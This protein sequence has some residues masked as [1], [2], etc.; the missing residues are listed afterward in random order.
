MSL[1]SSQHP[2]DA[3]LAAYALGRLDPTAGSWIE[4][5][6]AECPACRSVAE[7]TPPDALL[8]L[9]RKSVVTLPPQ[10]SAT[11]SE[12]PPSVDSAIVPAALH[13][14]PKYRIVRP[15]GQGGMGTVFL[16]EHRAME[17]LVAVKVV[18]RSLVDRP[19]AV[20]RF[21]REIKAAAKLD[22]PNIVRAYDAEPAGDLQLL[23]MEYVEGQSLADV[24]HESGPLPV[25]VACE[26]VR[27]AALG[28]QH[29]HEKGMVHRD[30]KPHNL[31]LA[32]TGVVKIL[33]FGL[34]KLASERRTDGLTRENAMMG[35]PEYLAPE[36]ARDT[37]AADVRA[38]IYALGCTLF[39]LLTGR[40]P[41]R[42]EGNDYLSVVLAHLEQPPPRVTDVR[43]DVPPTLANLIDRMLA[44]DPAE[45]PQTPG[46]VAAALEPFVAMESSRSRL[47]DRPL[48]RKRRVPAAL[49]IAAGG[50]VVIGVVVALT[51]FRPAAPTEPTTAADDDPADDQFEPPRAPPASAGPDLFQ[52]GSVWKG[53]LHHG[54]G[55]HPATLTV[56]DRDGETFRAR[57]DLKGPEIVRVIKKGTI[58]NGAIRWAI[59]DVDVTAG[60]SP[61]QD[62]TGIVA[63][64]RIT[65][66][67]LPSPDAPG[68]SRT[69]LMIVR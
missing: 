36:Q 2:P 22:H 48:R 35:T 56:L 63:G 14:H 59:K 24:L 33:D 64:P 67:G 3:D 68:R 51:A 11:R 13:D 57:L 44:K 43:P 6:L 54:K 12:V 21:G 39:C 58:K 30:I 20:E 28:L 8:A 10:S 47:S 40:P 23:V 46:E 31:M 41:F 69:D 27:Q 42:T 15:L 29:A 26:Y 61:G 18:N 5:H 7:H 60:R 17:R 4:L 34:A 55:N 50:A 16:A 49:A 45:R 19:D 1:T 9:L 52:K 32:P 38:D 62:V 37:A 66:Y 65:L 53:V 25:A